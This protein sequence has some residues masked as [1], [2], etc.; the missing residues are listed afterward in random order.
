MFSLFA[1][2]H[3]HLALAIGRACGIYLALGLYVTLMITVA[4]RS[5]VFVFVFVV[6][7]LTIRCSGLVLR[8]EFRTHLERGASRRSSNT[9]QPG[10]SPLRPPRDHPCSCRDQARVGHPKCE[11][12]QEYM[13]SSVQALD[14]RLVQVLV[15]K[16]NPNRSAGVL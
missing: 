11:G 6:F 14:V 1:E 12:G 15:Q 7:V 3:E 2:T 8:M 10:R 13:P 16:Q 9:A 4:V 5:F